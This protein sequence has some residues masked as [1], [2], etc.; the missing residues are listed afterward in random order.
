M[1]LNDYH[2]LGVQPNASKED[3]KS[4][5]QKLAKQYHPDRPQGNK[6]RFQEIQN[7]YEHITQ[8]KQ[9]IS[10]MMFRP[11]PFHPSFIVIPGGGFASFAGFP[12]IPVHTQRPSTA[13]RQ[14]KSTSVNVIH[15]N[16]KKFKRVTENVNGNIRITEEEIHE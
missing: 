6:E 11:G 10:P 3:I 7:A 1:T 13:P 2:I 5:Y 12:G 4:A 8:P 16:G 15:K 14:F 9:T